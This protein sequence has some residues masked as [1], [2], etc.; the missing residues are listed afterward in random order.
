MWVVAINPTSG[1]GRGAR[2]G[3]EVAGYLASGGHPY[4]IITGSSAQNL[5][6]NLA[7][8]V[9]GRKDISGVIA[10]GGDGL[11]HLVLQ[12]CVPRKIA[13]APIPAGTGNDF[14]R[15]LDWPLDGITPYLDAIVGR[16][17]E[18]IDLGLVDGEW[19]G[20]ILSTGFD[21]IVNERAN[22][23]TWPR[24]PWRYNAAIALEL[25]L[26]KPRHY[27]IRM[28]ERELETRAM[29]IAIANGVSY[30]GGMKVAPKADIRDGL[31]DVLVLK[32]V[33]KR[34]FLRVFPKVYSGQHLSHPAVE[35]HRTR[36]VSL[37]AD[38]VAYADGE[39]VGQLPITA[40]CIPQAGLT[41]RR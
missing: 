10:V 29:L 5:S 18:P 7:R 15:T 28:D 36:S 12:V 31:F 13:F 21:S 24:G 16:E 25:P 22:K 26:F 9:D 1:R 39:R 17:P 11:L 34:E 27:S 19:F 40:E 38:A 33:S 6:V 20:A 41:W 14:V 23:I 3:S 30:G 37:A 32:P 35:M 2:V 8:Y 4:E